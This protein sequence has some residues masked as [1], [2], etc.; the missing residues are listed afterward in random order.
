MNKIRN[1]VLILI[2]VLVI[3]GAGFLTVTKEP[4]K[5][6]FL[7]NRE[8]ACFEMPTV[9][10]ILDAS[11]QNNVDSSFADQFIQRSKFMDL[12][13]LLDSYLK[14]FVYLFVEENPMQ[15]V[16]VGDDGIF[17]VGQFGDRLIEFPFLYSSSYL[18]QMNV[19]INN[20][21]KMQEI[22]PET[23]IY[24]YKATNA[25]DT[26][27]FD[28]ENEIEGMGDSFKNTFL[29]NLDDRIR[30]GETYYE[31]WEDYQSKNYKTDHHWN[32]FGAYQGYEE[33]IA[34]LNQD[35]PEIGTPKEPVDM[36]TSEAQFFGSYARRCSYALGMDVYDSIG[37]FVYDL[38]EYTVTVD[39]EAVEDYGN[40]EGYRKGEFDPALGVNHYKDLFGQDTAEV[41]YDFGENTGL[42]L[43]ILS[44]SYSNAIKPVLA[45]HFDTTVFIDM[46]WYYGEFGEFFDYD[47]YDKLY[48]FDAVLFMGSLFTVYMDEAFHINNFY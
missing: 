46:R 18:D 42:N 47:K 29:E 1:L 21:N 24:L 35:F 6:S 26:S 13:N 30:Y 28:E 12:N 32:V 16:S 25:R 31:D 23:K 48:D 22:L 38:P 39:G 5:I 11:F 41:I 33:I 27:W 45:S 17:Q 2:F 3:C 7:E 40:R 43:L 36:F 10:T 44:D 34:L 14:K 9:P 37:D 8:M 19:R 4:E 20:Y 15:L